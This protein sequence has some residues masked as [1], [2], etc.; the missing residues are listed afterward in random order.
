MT[1]MTIAITLTSADISQ[2]RTSKEAGFSVKRGRCTTN[3]TATSLTYRRAA[4]EGPR[5]KSVPNPLLYQLN[6]QTPACRLH[7]GRAPPTDLTVWAQR[8]W[9][10]WKVRSASVTA[11][12]T[13]A[14]RW[15]RRICWRSLTC[16]ASLV[17]AF[18]ACLHSRMPVKVRTWRLP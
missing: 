14:F 3:V 8:L 4:E 12:S 10:D 11:S 5:D 1:C 18:K 17:I 9:T 2:Q 7:Q 16:W 15:C 6:P 13:S